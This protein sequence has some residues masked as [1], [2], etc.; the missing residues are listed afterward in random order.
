M[1]GLHDG[2][3]VGGCFA[4]GR[5]IETGDVPREE[6]GQVA[7]SKNLYPTLGLEVQVGCR[8]NVCMY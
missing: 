4:W 5:Q 2:R 3:V 8:L 7:T 6:G 1:M